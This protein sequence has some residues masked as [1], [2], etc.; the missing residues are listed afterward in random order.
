MLNPKNPENPKNLT[1]VQ[2]LKSPPP[3]W[4]GPNSFKNLF[5]VCFMYSRH[6]RVM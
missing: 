2:T 1:R 4:E 3:L 6:P 5:H